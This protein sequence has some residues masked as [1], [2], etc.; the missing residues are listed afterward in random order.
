MQYLE[1]NTKSKGVVTTPP[2][3]V[4]DVAKSSLVAWGLIAPEKCKEI[5]KIGKIL[6]GGPR[7]AKKLRENDF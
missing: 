4:A 2:P 7:T 5:G 1:P 3:L 6:F